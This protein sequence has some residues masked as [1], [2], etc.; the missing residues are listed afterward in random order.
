MDRSELARLL[1][2]VGPGMEGFPLE[3]CCIPAGVGSCIV[4]CRLSQ[5][6]PRRTRDGAPMPLPALRDPLPERFV[7]GATACAGARHAR[8]VRAESAQLRA[9][10]GE[11][12]GEC[13]SAA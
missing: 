11:C 5:V 9:L 13:S 2:Y 7:R 10:S 4:T 3:K 12:A 6:R 1:C 8:A